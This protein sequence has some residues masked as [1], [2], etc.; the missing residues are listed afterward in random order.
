[1]LN[2][3]TLFS[4][5][6]M[7]PMPDR[8]HPVTLLVLAS[9]VERTHPPRVSPAPD[10]SEKQ[11]QEQPP[12]FLLGSERCVIVGCSHG[13]WRHRLRSLL[14]PQLYQ[15]AKPGR[16]CRK[17][18]QRWAPVPGSAVLWLSN[19]GPKHR[20]RGWCL[21]RAWL[22]GGSGAPPRCRLLL[23]TRK[24]Q[25]KHPPAW[26]RQETGGR[27]WTGR[28]SPSSWLCTQRGGNR[29]RLRIF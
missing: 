22:S 13:T 24:T 18:R 7:S 19:G 3:E 8:H 26:D 11:L 28:A 5:V 25:I 2:F 23:G 4:G 12:I 20:L 6:S 1:M 10:F 15:S 29:V 16:E 27:G 17:Q 21:L 9:P 14:S